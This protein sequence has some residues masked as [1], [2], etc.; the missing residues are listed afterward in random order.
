MSPQISRKR[1]KK[2]LIILATGALILIGS[3]VGY[4]KLF[5]P[6]DHSAPTEDF[7]VEEG[8]TTW[9]VATQLTEKGYV[10]APWIF[11]IAYVRKA[12]G[13]DIL[14]GGYKISKSM[15]PWSI[16]RVLVEPPYQAWVKI[17]VG[18]RKEE[19]AEILASRLGWSSQKKQEFLAAAKSN[20]KNYVEGIYL[21]HTYFIPSDLTPPQVEAK[22][23]AHFTEAFAPYAEE[24]AQKG[25]PWPTVLTIASLIQR[26]AGSFEDMLVISGVIQ[27]R[28]AVGMPL[29]LDATLQYIEGS[30]ENG[31]WS[32]PKR[33]ASYPDSPFN[34]YKNK[35]L[36]PHPIAAPSL[37]AIEAALNPRDTNCLFYI[38][39]LNGRMHCSTTFKQHQA[40]ISKYLK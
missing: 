37:S 12:Y 28:L 23:R 22:L 6:V 35:G 21:A 16:A 33:A 27:N 40:F 11:E 14:P 9:D 1:R 19:V 13:N 39:D 20:G 10:R 32:P 30:E 5:G 17:P 25:I 38:H 7:F 8:A 15:D 36:P 34:T 4:S 18:V 29:A 2:L 26:E 24:A 31:W 3:A